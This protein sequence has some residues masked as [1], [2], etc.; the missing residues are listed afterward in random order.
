MLNEIK[1]NLKKKR[2]FEIFLL[3]YVFLKRFLENLAL[4]MDV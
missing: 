3:L 4:L 1:E 2:C